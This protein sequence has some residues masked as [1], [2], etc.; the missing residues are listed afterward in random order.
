M[1]TTIRT[2]SV[3]AGFNRLLQRLTRVPGAVDKAMGGL[4]D[5]VIARYQQNIAEGRSPKG[6][7]KKLS[8]AYAAW[9]RR[10]YPSQ[11]IL[12][13]TGS[14][15]N[16]LARQVKWTSPTRVRLSVGAT[17]VDRKGRSNADKAEWH[18]DGTPRMPARKFATLPVRFLDQA[19]AARAKAAL[20]G[21][22]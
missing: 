7:F 5:D 2:V 20:Q 21:R 8:P 13:A 4:G 11:P 16:S 3:S 1:P 15:R 9:K 22:P 18:Q 17:G 12:V 10:H 14:M 19:F 6:K